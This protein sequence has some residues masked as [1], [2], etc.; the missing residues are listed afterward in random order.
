MGKKT[1]AAVCAVLLAAGGTGGWYYYENVYKPENMTS[2][3]E[4]QVYMEH[5]SDIISTGSLGI[6]QRF[7]G[8]VD[9][10]E[11]LDINLDSSKKL[12]EIFVKEGDE[13]K[14]GDPLFSYDLEEMERKIQEADLEL[15]EMQNSLQTMQQQLIELQTQAA[16]AKPNEQQAYNLEILSMQNTINKQ[17]YN[18][19][20]KQLD[21][22]Q[23]EK[24]MGSSVVSS[25][26]HGIVR[27]INPN[28]S[29][30][31]PY[32]YGSGSSDAFMTILEAGDYRIKGTCNEMTVYN[33]YIGQELLIHPRADETRIYTGTVDKIDTEPA[34]DNNNNGFF[35]SP[36]EGESSSKYHFYV[37]LN[38]E[39]DMM[40]G[41][42][43]VM[44]PDLGQTEVKEGLWLPSYYIVESEDESYVWTCNDKNKIVKAEIEI[45][46]R[47]EEMMEYQILDGITKKD[48][49]A[50]PDEWIEEGMS[51]ILPES[52]E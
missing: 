11:S 13:V 44:E 37:T 2:E 49:I 45:G 3:T 8:I 35:Y 9:T 38:E 31:D 23:L 42:H 14:I 41:Q 20:V 36:S 51:A 46:E 50:Y 21:R 25:E 12:D 39:M 34:K 27:S 22:S 30:G 15:E 26:I 47:D 19:T 29:S 32:G 40:L 18:I 10:Q 52:M 5:V 48:Y 16:K 6:A 43:V 28:V 7:I 1:I 4:E 17:V 24:D 33:L